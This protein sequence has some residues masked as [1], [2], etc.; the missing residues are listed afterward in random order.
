ME[1]RESAREGGGGQR[2]MGKRRNVRG[3]ECS[4]SIPG[5]TTDGVHGKDIESVV[6]A[7]HKLELGGVVA[8]H[9]ADGAKDDGG[10]GG[11]VTRAGRDGDEAGDDAGA[12]ADGGP[13]ALE[14]VVEQT[15]GE[16]ADGGGEVG[17]DGGHDGAQVGGGGRAGVEAEPTD[18]E[19]DGA[20]HDVGDVVRPI[21]ELVRAV[22][23]PLA[24]HERVRERGRAGR[25]V[26]GRAAGE[27]ERA[28]TREPAVRV[29][30]PA[31]DRVVDDGRP[32]EHED[33]AR[34]HAP[35][36]G[37]GTDGEGDAVFKPGRRESAMMS[38]ARVFMFGE[39]QLPPH[40]LRG[41]GWGEGRGGERRRGEERRIFQRT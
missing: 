34:E 11:D 12:E 8:G 32:D 33:D 37:D 6:D 20:E 22:A 31:R 16:A 41:R 25:D 30:A 28:Q 3:E 40:P 26:D 39:G 19:E 23:A 1:E 10:P 9:G 35:A 18:P 15:P 24:E 14:T 17:G 7:E 13:L 27:V 29:P 36:F 5:E 38:S 21:V 4:Q 2:E